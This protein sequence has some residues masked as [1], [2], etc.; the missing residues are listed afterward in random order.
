MTASKH[1]L[2]PVDELWYKDTSLAG[3]RIVIYVRRCNASKKFYIE[4]ELPNHIWS[5]KGLGV[6]NYTSFDPAKKKAIIVLEALR[7]QAIRVRNHR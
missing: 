2:H 4:Y 6:D 5:A 3:A 7:T 1:I